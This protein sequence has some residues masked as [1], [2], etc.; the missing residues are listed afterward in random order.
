MIWQFYDFMCFMYFLTTYARES[1]ILFVALGSNQSIELN[2]TLIIVG[3]MILVA[4]A[5][6]L[7]T[8]I[9]IS[10]LARRRNTGQLFLHHIGIAL[11]NVRLCGHS[12]ILYLHRLVLSHFRSKG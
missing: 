7:I 1:A 3:L 12:S 10:A 2:S 4:V 8:V 11:L 9:A 5:M 6:L